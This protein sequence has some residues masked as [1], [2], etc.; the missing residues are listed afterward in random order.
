MFGEIYLC[1]F[2]FTSGTHSKPRPALVLFDFEKD[3]VICRIT[4]VI[5]EGMLEV[6]LQDW[7]EAG[8]AKA[9]VARLSRL[10]TADKTIFRRK[11]GELSDRDRQCV[12]EA[13]NGSMRL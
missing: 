4:S 11:L 3:A 9:S 1:E 2:P 10:V 5:R 12:Q 7:Q 8:L 6:V 13:W